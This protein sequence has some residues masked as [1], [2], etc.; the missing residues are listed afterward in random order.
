MALFLPW[1][2]LKHIYREKF[3]PKMVKRPGASIDKLLKLSSMVIKFGK[4]FLWFSPLFFMA[5]S[6]SFY[7]YLQFDLLI[8]ILFPG[9][10]IAIILFEY[11]FQKGLYQYLRSLP[12]Q[13]SILELKR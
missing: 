1:E 10:L 4:I 9:L 2:V 7:K 8:A 11:L 13:S 3:F 12:E 5:A 6:W